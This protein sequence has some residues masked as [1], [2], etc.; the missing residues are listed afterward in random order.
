MVTASICCCPSS[1]RASPWISGGLC[2]RGQACAKSAALEIAHQFALKAVQ[3]DPSLPEGRAAL[4]F[5][6]AW[7]RQHEA[8][9]AEIERAFA[10][11]PNYVDWR[12]GLALVVAGKS[13]RAL[14]VLEASMRLDP[15]YSPV[16]TFGLGMAH[17]MLKQYEQALMVLRDCVSRAPNLRGAHLW[18]V[19]TY[20]RLGR[21]E[22]ARA[23]VV[24]VLRKNPSYSTDATTR[25]IMGFKSAED[26]EHFFDG[27]RKA[28]LPE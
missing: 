17:Y 15:F 10:L 1:A 11:N 7:K 3:L 27:L 8:S 14:D 4:G 21:M 18:L 22:E 28:G 13:R 6:L 12:L 26:A 20:A 25:R 19:A 16:A 2:L 24:E 5:V 23:E 9:L